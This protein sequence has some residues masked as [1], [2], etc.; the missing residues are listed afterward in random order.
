MW[1][2]LLLSHCMTLI[3]VT[4]LVSLFIFILLIALQ[5][6]NAAAAAVCNRN[7]YTAKKQ[8]T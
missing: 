6:E 3:S 1:S 5:S 2:D 4:I 8:A 7:Q